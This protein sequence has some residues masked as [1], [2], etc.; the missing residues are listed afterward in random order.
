MVCD[1]HAPFFDFEFAIKFKIK[2]CQDC[3]AQFL[4]SCRPTRVQEGWSRRGIS[5]PCLR[6]FRRKVHVGDNSVISPSALVKFVAHCRTAYPTTKVTIR[7]EIKKG[8][9][10]DTLPFIFS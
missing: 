2:D 8:K 10:D 6:T 1:E 4:Y 9:V 7:N 3:L 5:P